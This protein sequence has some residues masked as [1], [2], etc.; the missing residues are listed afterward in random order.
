[1]SNKYQVAFKRLKN[2][3]ERGN[4]D[5]NVEPYL[6]ILQKLVDK[7]TPKKVID[8][9]GYEDRVRCPHCEHILSKSHAMYYCYVC[10]GKF[11]Q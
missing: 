7:E 4:C 9:I 3:I 8:I 10:G 2:D 1:M 11:Y 6:N 5:Y